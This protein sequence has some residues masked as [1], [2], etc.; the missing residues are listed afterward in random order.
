MSVFCIGDI[1]GAAGALDSLLDRLPDDSR[2]WFVGD[3]V[4]RGPDSAAVLRRVRGDKG[5]RPI[6]GTRVLKGS[7]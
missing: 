3:L 1:H 6:N 2:L 5:V 7:L 4:N